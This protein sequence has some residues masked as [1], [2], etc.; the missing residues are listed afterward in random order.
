MIVA[1]HNGSFHADELIGCMILSFLYPDMQIIRTRD[2]EKLDSADLVLDVGGK[3]DLE[4]TFDHHPSEFTLARDNKAKFA[5]AGLIWDKYGKDV[6]RLLS[7]QKNLLSNLPN[8]E[9]ELIIEKAFKYIDS[10]IM[11]Y[12][13][14]V[15][16]GQ[17]D[18]YLMEKSRAKENEERLDT[19][20]LLN[21]FHNTV[22]SVSYLIAF[23]NTP[24][25]KEQEQNQIFIETLNSFKFLFKNLFTKVVYQAREEEKVLQ[26][27]DG[28]EILMLDERLPWLNAVENNFEIFNN[29][30]LVIYPDSKKGWRIQSLPLSLASRFINRLPAPESWRGKEDQELNKLA[31]I[32]SG[33]FVHKTGFTG[34][35]LTKDDILI[36]AQNWLKE[37]TPN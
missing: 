8:N 24:D 37:A 34:G 19:F 31:K 36:M 32:S 11:T 27:Y 2:Q 10:R 17:L 13:D 21:E 22:P 12:L 1:T 7:N 4:R 25:C 30:K 35:A 9:Q 15:D 23:Q 29:C 3:F 6:L 16:N 33:T 18:S 20:N 14:L 26:I 28:S 5:S